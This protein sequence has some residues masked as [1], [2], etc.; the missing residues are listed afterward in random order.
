MADPTPYNFVT[1]IRYYK[2]NDPYYYEVDNIPLRQLEENILY[3]KDKVETHAKMKGFVMEGDEISIYNIKELRPKVDGGRTVKVNAGRFVS[4][5]NDA[6]DMNKPLAQLMVDQYA[7]LPKILPELKQV[8]TT[9]QRDKVWSDFIGPK[10]AANAYN[11]NGLELYYSFYS[12]PVEEGEWGSWG[13]DPHTNEPAAVGINYPW[14]EGQVWP[15]NTL[16]PNIRGTYQKWM[17][18]NPNLG[19]KLNTYSEPNGYSSSNLPTIHLMF[20]QMWR[21]VFRTAVVDVPD[22][23]IEVPAF[24]PGDF[25]YYDD[26]NEWQYLTE[27]QQR[28]DLLVAYSLP[29]DSSAT[30]IVDYQEKL[31]G[32]QQSDGTWTPKKLTKPMLGIVMG[33]GVGI[34]RDEHPPGGNRHVPHGIKGF[35]NADKNQAGQILA[36][37]SDTEP[38]ANVG[39][40]AGNDKPLP[41]K[42]HGSFPSPDDLLN[43]APV[44]ALDVTGLDQLQLVGQ[45]A[46]PLAYIVVNKDQ[47]E[48]V[49]EN[50]IDIRPF[51]RTTEF[52]YNERAGVAAAN[53]PLSFAN[54]AVGA[55]QL[56]SVLDA[57]EEDLQ[58]QIDALKGLI[59]QKPAAGQAIYTDHIMGGLAF[60]VEGAMLAM[61]DVGTGADDPWGSTTQNKTYTSKGNAVSYS[62]A[63]LTSSKEY[64]LKPDRMLKTA[65]LEYIVNER[66]GDLKRWLSNPSVP[67][68]ATV[69]T[70]LDLPAQDN[71]THIGRCIPLWP[72]WDMPV[73]NLTQYNEMVGTNHSYGSGSKSAGDPF[74]KSG[75]RGRSPAPTYWLWMEG[76]SYSRPMRYT[77]GWAGPWEDLQSGTGNPQ[78]GNWPAQSGFGWGGGPLVQPVIE[79]GQIYGCSKKLHLQMPAWVESYDVLTE[80]S[81][82]SPAQGEGGGSGRSVKM[83]TGLQVSKGSIDAGGGATIIIT[84]FAN[85]GDASTGSYVKDFQWDD[86]TNGYN[87]DLKYSPTPTK[88]WKGWDCASNACGIPGRG[89]WQWMMYSVI[90]PQFPQTKYGVHE[91][92]L[93][94]K[95]NTRKIPKV[96]GAFLPTVK[97]TIIGYPADPVFSNK[98]YRG[99]TAHQHTML[100]G[101]GN[102]GNP[103]KADAINGGYVPWQKETIIDIS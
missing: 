8:W 38:D 40:T 99:S 98:N 18:G 5:I 21:G 87:Y 9:A 96:G 59:T 68:T 85:K 91:S 54:P 61:C 103:G 22:S 60:G 10:A 45:A 70:Y 75:F 29:I 49:K 97:F 43:I 46:L 37:I 44:M 42:I 52:T 55:Y 41:T 31:S 80:Y 30:H 19:L 2:A 33:A 79:S 95:T 13:V 14:Y 6:F 47:P 53:P 100:Y 73:E 83:A 58:R 74:Y 36:N 67:A 57:Q 16:W 64:M 24:N 39:I 50:I 20:V 102:A 32:S 63:S 84:S 25:G 17:A 35:A 26:N 4:R 1:P 92:W 66:Q 28:I 15:Q 82:C 89:D 69:G 23:T 72:E 90:C 81:N 3:V 62:F 51:L 56:H 78:Q 77:S 76:Q 94:P 11:T 88:S 12:T 27:A 93:P 71:T 101:I 34:A 48:I 65:Y 86:P 7:G